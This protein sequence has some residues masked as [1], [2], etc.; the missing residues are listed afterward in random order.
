MVLNKKINPFFILSLLAIVLHLSFCKKE[1]NTT[2]AIDDGYNYFSFDVG[3]YV[4]YDVDSI[5]HNDF[6]QQ[7]DTFKYQLK[8]LNESI[9]L[10]NSGRNTMRK[11]RYKRNY[12]DTVAYDLMPW[13]LI[14]ASQANKTNTTVEETENNVRYVKLNFPV[15]KDKS[16]NGNVYNT[17]GEQ[18][19]SYTDIHVSRTIGT[20][21]FDSTLLVTQI[22]TENLIEKKYHIEIYATNIGLVDKEIT[23][24]KSTNIVAGVP[25]MKRITSGVEY[26]MTIHSYGSN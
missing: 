2:I 15:K 11:E 24:V 26:K 7:V 20:I 21:A 3:K 19:Y 9:F 10:D 5:V 23:D 8:E 16:W 12:N 6:T 25:L 18:N 4:I 1:K 14:S 13:I 17:L 22:N